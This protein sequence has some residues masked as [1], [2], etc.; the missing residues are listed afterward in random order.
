MEIIYE[1]IATNEEKLFPS[2]PQRALSITIYPSLFVA[3]YSKI[4]KWNKY[5]K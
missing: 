1:Y 3:S 4:A 2:L 5:G